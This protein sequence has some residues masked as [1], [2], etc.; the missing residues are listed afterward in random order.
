MPDWNAVVLF[1]KFRH[2]FLSPSFDPL[3]VIADA[4]E[5]FS[6][7]IPKQ[8]SYFCATVGTSRNFAY[9][10]MPWHDLNHVSRVEPD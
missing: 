8:R 1:S 10:L 9:R 4:A 3:L 5:L 7:L 6:L 2:F